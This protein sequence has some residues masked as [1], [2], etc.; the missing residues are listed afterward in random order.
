M[1]RLQNNGQL[2]LAQCSCTEVFSSALCVGAYRNTKMHTVYCNYAASFT[3]N[4]QL[5]QAHVGKQIF[6][7]FLCSLASYAKTK[8]LQMATNVILDDSEK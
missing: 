8:C 1:D 3:H 7:C 2:C 5:L 4:T 6:L